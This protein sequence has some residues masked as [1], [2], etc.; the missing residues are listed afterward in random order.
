ML[1]VMMTDLH[2]LFFEC[3]SRMMMKMEI[4]PFLKEEDLGAFTNCSSAPLVP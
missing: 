3:N 1:M 2:K 4:N